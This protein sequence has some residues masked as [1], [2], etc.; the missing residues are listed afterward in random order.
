MQQLILLLNI[1]INLSLKIPKKHYSY[2]I[3][4][5]GETADTLAALR[6]VKKNKCKI[7]S[8]VNVI[9]SS[10]ARESD[11]V[12]SIAA[13]P[14]IGG[15]DKSFFSSAMCSCFF[16]F[17]NGKRKKSFIKITEL[18]LTESLLEIPSSILLALDMS[19]IIKVKSNS[20]VN[21]KS[22]LFLGR[23][24]SFPIAME[25]ALKLKEIT[26]I[27]A[28]GYASGEMKHGPIALVDDKV[29]VVIISPKDSLFEKNISNMQEIMA[30]GKVLLVTE[31][32][33][34]KRVLKILL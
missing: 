34:E 2:F 4:Q 28:E 12:L 18:I 14:E 7:L 21:A 27:H 20:I 16:M 9:E 6:F 5:S 32:K 8:L 10:I 31:I 19:D 17:G 23:G 29:P 24:S 26:Y 1:D 13:G 30:R 33:M 22:A 15:F 3:S 25:G 11:F